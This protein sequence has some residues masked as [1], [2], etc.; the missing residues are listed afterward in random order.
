LE[1]S[2]VEWGTVAE[3]VGALGTIGAFIAAVAVFRKELDSLHAERESRS[4]ERE[5][6]RREHARTVAVW[7]DDREAFIAEGVA[8]TYETTMHVKNASSWPVHNCVAYLIHPIAGPADDPAHPDHLAAS[9]LVIGAVPPGETVSEVVD[10][11]CIDRDRVIFPG[12]VAE[13]AFTDSAGLHWRRLVD[14]TLQEEQHM[15]RMC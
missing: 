6:R 9:E 4:E 11:D 10:Q 15:P 8:P 5:L 14:G 13:V 1:W 3:W 12:L 7:V 2:D